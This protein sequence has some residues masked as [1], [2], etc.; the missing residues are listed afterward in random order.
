Y[1]DPVSALFFSALFL[2][3]SLSALQIA[4]A[5]LIIGGAVF[6]EVRGKKSGTESL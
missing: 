1:I 4:G 5:V 2:H 6:G 3:E